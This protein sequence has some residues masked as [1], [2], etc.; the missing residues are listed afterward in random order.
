LDFGN[1][2]DSGG[3]RFELC[4]RKD[5]FRLGKELANLL[6]NDIG[7]FLLRRCG[8]CRFSSTSRAT[9]AAREVTPS[10]TKMRRR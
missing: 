2:A 3:D 8:Y 1:R 10:L 7:G 9:I 6:D 4:L 5:W